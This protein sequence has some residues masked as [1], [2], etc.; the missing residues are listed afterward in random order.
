MKNAYH[1]NREFLAFLFTLRVF[2]F[3]CLLLA[4]SKVIENDLDSRFNS[5]NFELLYNIDF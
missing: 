3:K 1:V 5:S 4:G 2:I